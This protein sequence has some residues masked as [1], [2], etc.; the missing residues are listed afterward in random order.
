[1]VVKAKKVSMLV[2]MSAICLQSCPSTPPEHYIPIFASDKIT[3]EAGQ[4]FDLKITVRSGKRKYAKERTGFDG[5][6]CFKFIQDGKEADLTIRQ[7]DIDGGK[8]SD[9]DRLPCAMICENQYIFPCAKSSDDRAT[10]EYQDLYFSQEFSGELVARASDRLYDGYG[11][12]ENSIPIEITNNGLTGEFSLNDATDKLT[13]KLSNAK[14]SQQYTINLAANIN[15][16]DYGLAKTVTADADG[17][18]N[19]S[20]TL[21]NKTDKSEVCA[22]EFAAKVT[23]SNEE[24]TRIIATEIKF[25]CNSKA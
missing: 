11:I 19:S 24:D 15:Y 16:L 1:M 21:T 3:Q 5:Y 10:K 18:A 8:V 2:V 25:P 23:T 7:W 22:I 12:R 6:I 17:K 13:L 20:W 4:L 9:K 14:P